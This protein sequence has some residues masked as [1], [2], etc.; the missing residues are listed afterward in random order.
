MIPASADYIAYE[1]QKIGATPAVRATFLP[2]LWLPGVNADGTFAH[3]A[4]VAPDRIQADSGGFSGGYWISPV[5][6]ANM[7]VDTSPAKLSW[8][9]NTVGYALLIYYRAADDETALAA[10]SWTLV[11]EGGTVQIAP[12]YQFKLTLEGFRAWAV[13]ASGDADDFTAWAV[14][15][16]GVEAEQGYA[17]E[18][19]NVPG[20]LLTYI[21]ALIL[22]GEYTIIRDIE[23]AGSLTME[24]P[25]AFDDLVAGSHSGLL[26]N[27]RQG[28]FDEDLVWTPAPFFS[29]GKSS[30]FLHGQD[31][32][33]LNLRIDFGWSKEGFLA[34]PFLEDPM[35]KERFT[36]Y[37][38]LFLGR[39]KKWGPVTR[40]VGSANNV[41]V[42][43]V[44]Y[45]SDCLQKRICLPAADGTPNPLTFGEF[46]C[47]GEAVAGWSPAPVDRSAYFAAD[48]YSELNSVI[49]SGSGA[50][51][52]ITPGI[53]GARAFRA[54]VSTAHDVAMGSIKLPAD[55]ETFITGTMR[56]TS[57]PGTIHSGDMI[58]MMVLGASG[59][60]G[61]SSPF[62][63][64][65]TPDGSMY[66]GKCNV[67]AYEGVPLSFALWVNPASPGN[68]RFW[69]NGEEVFTNDYA[70]WPLDIPSELRFGAWLGDSSEVWTVDFENIEV[71]SHYYN[72][73]FR[74][75]GSPF[76]SIGPVYI[77]NVGQPDSKP[78]DAF[79]QTL[80]RFPEYGMV[81]F[82]ST[83]PAFKPSGEVM[84]RVVE[85]A[86]GRHALAILEAL[87][88]EAGL[89]DYIDAPSLAAAYLAVPE[90]IIN[91][92]FDGSAPAKTGP[93]DYAT[94]G[95][96]AADAV[97]EICSRMLYW[98]F[99]DAGKIKIVP[100][101]G[102]APVD[103][104]LAL[105]ASN[106]WENTQ[107]IDL[108]NQNAFVSAVY[109]WY[110]RNSS[111][112]CLAGAQDAGG[113]GTSLYYSWGGPVCCE[114]RVV[115][116]AKVDL[117]LKFLSA[118][119]RIDP[120]TMTLLGARLELMTDTVSLRDELLNDAAQ[121][122]RVARKEV[123][124]D[125]GG[126][127]TTLQLIRF[128]GE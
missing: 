56:F 106:K 101:T 92:R 52:L 59:T 20:D 93:K 128:L 24:A 1:A 21:E 43:A 48:D 14:D 46:L 82:T 50:A 73:A 36:E 70:T 100:Y 104:V 127:T 98:F 28:T 81:Q 34:A 86:G 87:I 120:V 107:T 40:A 26:L 83:D 72:N 108:E 126:R 88:A 12:F 110:D 111:L 115:V 31:W 18:D 44:D 38:T 91:A 103:P 58:P 124:L 55:G 29:P 67:Y 68:V 113:Q 51:S 16:A 114:N 78:V 23:Q 19:P 4:Y 76:A 27:N 74:V 112:F 47:K 66:E 8:T 57:V 42:Y 121:N 60:I 105:T 37:L 6:T 65:F 69:L 109:G 63:P 15:V 71:R 96:P 118:Q 62:L 33:D 32:Y 9:W 64:S 75:T 89:T 35:F 123:G 79:T 3:C 117:L 5:L 17:V 119:D 122:Y 25:R 99:M 125:K 22:T 30:F 10:A 13:D 61:V 94:L 84:F 97:K 90:D 53:N 54:Q 7:Q 2:Y 77:D 41:E 102:T 45:I 11:N 49:Q 80:T 95:I 85:H 39:V 116:Q